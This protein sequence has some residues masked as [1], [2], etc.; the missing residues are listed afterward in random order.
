MVFDKVGL[1]YAGPVYI[2]YSDVRKST[3]VKAYICVFVSLSLKAVTLEVVS[4][5]TTDA[6][7]ASLRRFIAH[8][9]KPSCV[10]S[11]HRTNCVGAVR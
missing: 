2:K 5:L 4:E 7:I 9:G 3:I 1:D 10:W 8:C 11:D 6:F